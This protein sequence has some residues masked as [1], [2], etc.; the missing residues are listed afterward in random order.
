MEKGQ[1]LAEVV[2]ALVVLLILLVVVAESLILLPDAIVYSVNA[3]AVQALLSEYQNIAATFEN[4]FTSLENLN[5]N[6]IYS[7]LPT[8]TGWI[9]ATGQE[10]VVFNDRPYY[11]WFSVVSDLGFVHSR[12]T[13]VKRLE[14]NV[15]DGKQIYPSTLLITN[16]K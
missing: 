12:S 8:T 11:R 6:A 9:I 7:F 15:N 2:I 1:F 13:N 3:Q 10:R 16:W 5:A 4:N 14:I